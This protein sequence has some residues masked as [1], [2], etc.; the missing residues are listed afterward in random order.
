[1]GSSTENSAFFTTRNP[2]DL[3]ARARRLLRRLGGRGRGR[4]G[5]RRAR[6]RHRRLDPPAGGVLRRRRAQADLRARLAL[7]PGR[8]RL[9]A[10]PDRPLH[11]TVARRRAA[12]SRRSP[13][14]TRGLDL[15]ADAGARLRGRRSSGGVDGLRIGVPRE[16]FVDGIDPEVRAAR[17]ERRSRRCA[18]S[19]RETDEVSLPHTEYGARRL[20]HH[21]A[22]RGLVEPR[23]LRRRQVRP[24]RARRRDLGEHVRASTRGA[25][26]GDEVKRRI[27]LGTYALSAGYYDAYYLQGAEGAHADPPRLR[28]R[29]RATW[30]SIVAPTSPTPAFKIGEKSTTRCRCTSPTSSRSR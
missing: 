24:A 13:A 2:W 29:L 28:R 1:M 14:T 10:R 15:G 8:L 23:A 11:R 3:D 19:A 16:Y 25:G 18:G 30:T 6:H 5:R 26:F 12:C 21:R 22:R 27:M 17:C 20:L 4:H 7:R 9:V